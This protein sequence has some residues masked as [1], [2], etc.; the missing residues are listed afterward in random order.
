LLLNPRKISRRNLAGPCNTLSNSYICTV[1]CTV[2]VYISVSCTNLPQIL[3][4]LFCLLI[5][6]HLYNLWFCPNFLLVWMNKS[7]LS[8]ALWGADL[9]VHQIVSDF[10]HCRKV[11][12]SSINVRLKKSWITLSRP[13]PLCEY[14]L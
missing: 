9:K 8:L 1:Q 14:R 5:Y 11:F 4:L 2:Y 6:I 10:L 3:C 12:M 7:T 13:F